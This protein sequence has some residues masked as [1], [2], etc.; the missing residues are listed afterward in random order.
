MRMIPGKRDIY[1]IPR[2]PHLILCCITNLRDHILSFAMRPI[3]LHAMS[4]TTS[5]TAS[6]PLHFSGGQP[7]CRSLPGPAHAQLFGTACPLPCPR[8]TCHRTC[9]TQRTGSLQNL[10]TPFSSRALRRHAESDKPLIRIQIQY[11]PNFC[12]TKKHLR[13]DGLDKSARM[14]SFHRDNTHAW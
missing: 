7:P 8:R 6:F 2:H 1:R 11:A 13:P 4:H 12:R 9:G 3:N 5:Q 14:G 10:E